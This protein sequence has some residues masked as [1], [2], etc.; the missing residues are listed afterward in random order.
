MV[1]RQ[2]PATA[3]ETCDAT[4]AICTYNRLHT[5]PRTLQSLK[6]LRG[7]YCFEIVVV[8]GP[9]DDGT[10]EFLEGREGLRSFS[11]PEANLSISRNIAIANAAGK[12]IAFIDDDAIP[13]PDWLTRVIDRFE[14]EPDV[15]AVGGFIRDANGI[16]FQAQ[17]T[18]CDAFGNSY[19]CENPDYATFPAREKRLYP[20]LTGTNVTFRKSALEK[21]GGFDEVFAYYLDET[22]VNKRMDDMGM[23]ALV[24]PEAEIHHKYAPSHLRTETNV[25]RDMFPIARSVGYFALRHAAPELG[26]EAVGKRLKDFYRSEFRWKSHML[27]AG[28]IDREKLSHLMHQVRRGL[29][30]GVDAYFDPT[31]EDA[32][33][34]RRV[35]KHH[36]PTSAPALHRMRSPDEGLR[37]CMFSRDH[38]HPDHGGIGRWSNLVAKGLAERGNEVTLIGEQ[39]NSAQQQYCDFTADGYWSHNISFHG[40]EAGNELDCLGLPEDLA[41]MSK[42]KRRE[43]LR[44][45]GRRDFQVAGTPIWD[46]EGAAVIGAR[47]LPTVLSLHTC[48]GIMLDSKPEWREDEAFYHNHVLRSIN[49]EIQGLRRADMILANSRAIMCDISGLYGLDLFERPHVI[50][51]HGIADIE[52]PEALVE[53]RQAHQAETGAPLRVLFLGRLETR[54]GIGHLVPVMQKILENHDNVVLDLVG[55]RVD[56]TNMALVQELLDAWPGRV[57]WHGFLEE[58]PL[59]QL[60]RQA[61][62]FFAPSLYESFGLIYAEAMRYS[63]PS[64]AYVAG[65]VPEVVEDG[66]DGLLAPLE[67]QQA[68]YDALDRLIRDADLRL[69]LSRAARTSFEE[70]FR[71]EL[72]AERLETVYRNAAIGT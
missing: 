43:M 65:G 41:N 24:L 33:P 35:E 63:V 23:R 62:I 53:K 51:P 6:M 45:M 37:L 26:W 4:V 25:P 21:I 40:R 44:V 50:V 1:P 15:D 16:A 70:K 68:L 8:N 71:Y 34:Q 47:D 18:F 60:M 42:R 49:A 64:V 72:M 59:D 57:T 54:K 27:A 31:P 19:P 52:A 48:T 46:M 39:H 12:Y 67:D 2:K 29:I 66:K 38:A 10:T 17:Y 9:S 3:Q 28:S 22:D 55:D 36:V 58:E 56:D 20:S 5:L 69:R 14:A 11:N 30:A 7:P 32:R 13:E 61:N